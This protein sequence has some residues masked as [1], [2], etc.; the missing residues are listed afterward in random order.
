M[1]L[2][3]LAGDFRRDVDVLNPP[4]KQGILVNDLQMWD[5][6]GCRDCDAGSCSGVSSQEGQEAMVGDNVKDGDYRTVGRTA[7]SAGEKGQSHVHS[8]SE[9]NRDIQLLVDRAR[10]LRKGGR[11]IRCRLQA[12]GIDAVLPRREKD[13]M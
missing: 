13:K 12:V 2:P 6:L 9:N 1:R 3:R 7:L 4:P 8:R 5:E 11:W 10:I